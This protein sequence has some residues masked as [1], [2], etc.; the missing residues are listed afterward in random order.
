MKKNDNSL[1]KNFLI[2]TYLVYV[3]V[4]TLQCTYIC[5]KLVLRELIP[6]IK[7]SRPIEVGEAAPKI[8]YNNYEIS[9]H[10]CQS[11]SNLLNL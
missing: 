8:I 3:F 4:S 11:Y 10:G 2:L 1:S 9:P 7:I 5:R 6:S